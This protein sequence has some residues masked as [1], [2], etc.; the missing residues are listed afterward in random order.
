ML[1]MFQ[2]LSMFRR[3]VMSCTL[4]SL[5]TRMHHLLSQTSETNMGKPKA[6]ITELR[7]IS[8]IAAWI[9]IRKRYIR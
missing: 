4:C 3:E 9:S 5:S 2:M 8:K 1:Q 6:G 7:M